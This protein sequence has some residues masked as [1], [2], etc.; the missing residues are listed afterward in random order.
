VANILAD[1][2]I[3]GLLVTEDTAIDDQAA[4][5]NRADDA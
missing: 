4:A 1:L 2:I 5:P 3:G